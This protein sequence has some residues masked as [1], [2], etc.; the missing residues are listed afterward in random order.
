M[1]ILF[2]FIYFLSF[3]ILFF[4]VKLNEIQN[5]NKVG[6]AMMNT[7]KWEGDEVNT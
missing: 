6:S 1:K 4:L 7:L 5:K 2:L 3:I